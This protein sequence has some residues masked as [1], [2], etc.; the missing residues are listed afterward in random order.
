MNTLTS[1]NYL[2]ST[3]CKPCARKHN[4][5]HSGH[6]VYTFGAYPFP[7]EVVYALEGEQFDG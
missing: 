2:P 3:K 1:V 6:I 7:P 5:V 4:W